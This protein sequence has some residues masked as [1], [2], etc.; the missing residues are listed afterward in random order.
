M[1]VNFKGQNNSCSFGKHYCGNWVLLL[2]LANVP[3]HLPVPDLVGADEPMRRGRA[4]CSNR[5][6]VFK[7]F[8]ILFSLQEMADPQVLHHHRQSDGGLPVGGDDRH[9]RNRGQVAS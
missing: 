1:H 9:R 2:R 3:S 6:T 5:Y 7:L 4:V 8:T